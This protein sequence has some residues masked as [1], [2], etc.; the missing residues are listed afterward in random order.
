MADLNAQR[1]PVGLLLLFGQ[2]GKQLVAL[3]SQFVRAKRGRRQAV[4]QQIESQIRIVGK[5]F[6]AAARRAH[7]Q[8]AAGVLDGAS[9][10]R[11]S[12]AIVVPSSSNAPMRAATPT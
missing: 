4:E 6:D 3:G 11:P 12:C 2:I 5:D 9:D 7:A 1:P 10:F 8:V